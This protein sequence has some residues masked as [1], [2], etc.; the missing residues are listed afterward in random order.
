VE[1]TPDE[2][3]TFLGL[4]DVKPMQEALLKQIQDQMAANLHAVDPDTMLKAWLPAGVQGIE[5]LQKLFWSQFAGGRSRE[6]TL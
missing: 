4:P 2:A 3:R 6:K 5:Q 1:C